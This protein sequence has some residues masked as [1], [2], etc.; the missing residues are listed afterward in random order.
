MLPSFCCR[1]HR[2]CRQARPRDVPS[3]DLYLMHPSR[4]SVEKMS[5]IERVERE[6]ERRER[7]RIERERE[8]ERGERQYGDSIWFHIEPYGSKNTNFH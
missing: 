4:C 7:E 8:R 1:C 5:S 2:R 3:D 6:R